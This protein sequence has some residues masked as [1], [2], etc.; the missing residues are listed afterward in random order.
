MVVVGIV[1]TNLSIEEL[2]EC[3]MNFRG[4]LGSSEDNKR[5]LESFGEYWEVR[6]SIEDY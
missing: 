4:V 3:I 5:V 1:L 6:R 2:L